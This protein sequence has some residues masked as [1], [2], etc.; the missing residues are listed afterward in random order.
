M[1]IISMRSVLVVGD[2]KRYPF[3][4]FQRN[5]KRLG[6]LLGFRSDALGTY[7]FDFEPLD[8][9]RKFFTWSYTKYVFYLSFSCEKS[10]TL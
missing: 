1:K 3:F 2:I 5:L 6:E 7:M 9:N 4:Y 8:F 10:Q